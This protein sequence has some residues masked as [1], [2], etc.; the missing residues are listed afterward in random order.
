MKYL[1]R[2]HFNLLVLQYKRKKFIGELLKGTEE[3]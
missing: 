3:S 1:I 2:T